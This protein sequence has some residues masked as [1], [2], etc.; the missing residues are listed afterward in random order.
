[1]SL[2]FLVIFDLVVL[3]E[4]STSYTTP[5][6]VSF[7][8]RSPTQATTQP[9]DEYKDDCQTV[10][11]RGFLKKQCDNGEYQCLSKTQGNNFTSYRVFEE[12]NYSWFTHICE[13]DPVYY[14]T[15]G[16]VTCE[17]SLI[18]QDPPF[19][20]GSFACTQEKTYWRK[21][22]KSK[23]Q[24][25]KW[26][27]TIGGIE[28]N[29][30]LCNGKNECVHS[31]IDEKSCPEV[32]R[33]C[34]FYNESIDATY[35]C[36]GK[37]D[38]Y[39]CED[40]FKCT[41]SDHDFGIYCTNKMPQRLNW[42]PRYSWPDYVPPAVICDGIPDCDDGKDEENC[43]QVISNT[44]RNSENLRG[45]Y[46]FNRPDGTVRTRDYTSAE[47]K[48]NDKN[49][50][51]VPNRLYLVCTDYRDQLNC[52]HA[53]ES[54]LICK[55]NKFETHISKYAL[56]KE[57]MLCDDRLDGNCHSPTG[58][59]FIHKHKF[60]DGVSDCSDAEDSP[61]EKAPDCKEMTNEFCERRFQR[62]N[63]RNESLA[64]PLAWVMD[65]VADCIDDFDENPLNWKV[66]GDEST[67]RY[68][69]KQNQCHDIF[70]CSSDKKDYTNISSLC[71]GRRT[72]CM[73]ESDIC[74]ISRNAPKTSDIMTRFP[75]TNELTIGM[76][77]PGLKDFIQL[78]DNIPMSVQMHSFNEPFGVNP[79]EVTIPKDKKIDCRFVYGGAE[80]KRLHL[81]ST[82]H[83][84]PLIYLIMTNN[85]RNSGIPQ[86]KTLTGQKKINKKSQ[87][88]PPSSPLLNVDV[89]EPRY[90]KCPCASSDKSSWLMK[91]T[92][93]TQNWHS[94]C[95]NLRGIKEDFVTQLE[96]WQCPLCFTP[97]GLANVQNKRTEQLLLSMAALQGKNT[98]LEKA[99]RH[100]EDKLSA[101]ISDTDQLRTSTKNVAEKLVKLSDIELHIQHR[102][103]QEGQ[104]DDRI[105]TMSS[106]L[107]NLQASFTELKETT[108]SS[109]QSFSNSPALRPEVKI[110]NS[111]EAFV[112]PSIESL[113]SKAT[114]RS[115]QEEEEFCTP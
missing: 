45:I 24:Y 83:T 52:S 11:V 4:L 73:M 35:F 100:L 57:T 1:M 94:N 64:I 67:K 42:G 75:D 78:Y 48:L 59:C 37:C 85:R 86:N 18:Q 25:K 53:L 33:S 44:C 54:P 5:H 66:C 112:E 38:C 19:V 103:I 32:S 87:P 60:C 21:T 82:K 46:K 108:E 96:D 99:V 30:I 104:F 74:R 97:P 61:D 22:G 80:S 23:W 88:P 106:Q 76:F 63:E 29:M 12:C 69:E 77:L 101:L 58:G 79:F 98:D 20:C 51:I 26:N 84:H 81:D 39:F 111:I 16:H 49:T 72:A 34:T 8:S 41:G 17:H 10:V 36:D 95:C 114:Q 109:G 14:Q 110:L 89:D 40:E 115:R 65:G 62:N 105:K 7:S 2:R 31:T 50:C 107:T 28:N 71:D 6:P 91:C 27:A 15:C 113:A 55:R 43:N 9:V 93:C 56:C 102:T 92:K 3:G 70:F 13:D 68:I 47:V 90:E